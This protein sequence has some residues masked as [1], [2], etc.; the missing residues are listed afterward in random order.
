MRLMQEQVQSPWSKW[1]PGLLEEQ[2]WSQCGWNGLNKERST[3]HNQWWVCGRGNRCHC[4]LC[5][6]LTC[7]CKSLSVF[8]HMKD[9]LHFKGLGQ[10]GMT[11]NDSLK[12]K[13][14][15]FI[16]TIDFRASGKES[17]KSERKWLNSLG[18]GEVVNYSQILHI[19]G[20]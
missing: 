14:S 1:R 7:I 10:R 20:D 13:R 5:P 9:I 2:K 19:F 8:L 3:K 18:R 15:V 11:W 16:L 6:G 17:G 4:V 12:K